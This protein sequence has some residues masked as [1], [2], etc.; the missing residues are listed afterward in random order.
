MFFDKFTNK[1]AETFLN[2][3]REAE[4]L[5]HS[6]IDPEHFLLA[7]LKDPNNMVTEIIH[8]Q[9]GI[10]YTAIRNSVIQTLGRGMR[11]ILAMSPTVSDSMRR[12]L[13]LSIEEAKMFGQS[14][15]A[16]EHIFLAAL[17]DGQNGIVRALQSLNVDST[18]VARELMSRLNPDTGNEKTQSPNQT[19]A[20]I[21]QLEDYGESLNELAKKG[22][23][24]PVI[25]RH[26]EI[27]RMMQVLVRR[28]KNNPVLMGE[29]GVGKTAIVEGLVERIVRE[30]VPEM[31][32]NKVVFSLDIASLVA[33]TKYRGEFEKRIKKMIQI[34]KKDP[35]IVLFIDELHTIVGAGAAEGAVDASNILKPSLANGDIRCIGATTPD[36]YRKY[37]EKD[38]AL[39]RRFQKIYVQ[40]PTTKE[41]L[42]ILQGLK[43]KYELH[44]KVQY[45]Q[46]ALED[47]V[48][49]SKAYITDH[50]L[51]D[52]AIDVIDEA[53]ARKRLMTVTIPEELKSDAENL[54]M[55][56]NKRKIAAQ[57]QDFL[58]AKKMQEEEREK[59]LLYNQKYQAWKIEADSR[60]E[61]VGMDDVAR[62][63]SSWTGIPLTRV[64]QDEMAKLLRLEEALHV[65]VV[66]Q[67]EPI[68]AIS[69]SIRRARSGLKDPKRPVGSFLFLGPTG[70]GKTELAKTLAEYL[71][72]DEKALLRFD[73]SEY[74]ERFSVS[75]LIGAPP[76][77]VGYEEGG[78]LTEAVRRRPFSAILLDEIEKAHPDTFNILLQI[79][80]DGRL[81]DS[82][83][84]IVD[85]RNTILIMT[86][87]IGGEIISK[88]KHT[89]GF[90]IDHSDDGSY[91]DMKTTV[92]EEVKKTFRP[93]FLNR[94]DETIVFHQLSRDHMRAIVNI[95]I[96]E[97]GQRMKEKNM[98]LSLTKN[99]KELLMEKGFDP[100]YGARPL[101]RIIQ[102]LVEDPLSEAILQKRFQSLDRVVISANQ[103]GEIVFKKG[104]PRKRVSKSGKTLAS[105]K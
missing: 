11:N 86:S 53:G 41:T 39:E 78:T 99:A 92:M 70:V 82:Q 34:V 6:K 16:M 31:L 62:V 47:A 50:F 13:E 102:K 58:S 14:H 63:I 59:A 96:S 64:A 4:A 93:E 8:G 51:P 83:G 32:K 54:Q 1:A 74:M 5:G 33:G 45:T 25:G 30:E 60:I 55:L 100:I 65:R 46:E 90:G 87:N 17:R 84:R 9:Y 44:H 81:T 66:G 68:E 43:E 69:R 101:K 76:G 10:E 95:L 48:K 72:G 91:R 7:V 73:M 24:D 61:T 98:T 85:F 26:T 19:A 77:Y 49:L 15:I 18:T 80:D 52:M 3:Q 71:F 56:R 20:L 37:I 28:K 103:K 12:I 23:L 36:E 57:Q 22:S 94:L 105:V 21:K 27:E 35:N 67:N 88:S 40:E 75:R 104:A 89:M 42:D 38:A 79:M 29:P 97:V 2:S